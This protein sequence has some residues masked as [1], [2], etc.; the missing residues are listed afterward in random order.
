MMQLRRVILAILFL[1]SRHYKQMKIYKLKIMIEKSTIL[2]QN[3]EMGILNV[4]ILGN[5]Q[6]TFS[7]ASLYAYSDT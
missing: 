7:Y 3:F 5:R 1:H 6:E 4:P 2:V